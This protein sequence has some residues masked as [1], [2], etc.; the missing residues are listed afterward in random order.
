MGGICGRTSEISVEKEMKDNMKKP[1]K[2]V[3]ER[4]HTPAN[5]GAEAEAVKNYRAKM[6]Q[7]LNQDEVSQK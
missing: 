1:K 6:L 5:I 7:E 3:A 2:K 4:R